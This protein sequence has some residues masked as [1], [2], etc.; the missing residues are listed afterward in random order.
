MTASRTC[1][2]CGADLP[3][4]VRW[5]LRCYEP[6]RELTP[7]APVWGDDEFVD[8]PIVTKGPVPHWSRWEKS[9]TTFGPA[10][11]VVV[12][13]LAA[14]WLLSSAFNTPITVIFVLPLSM[15]IVRNVWRP[16]WVIPPHLQAP[17]D[18]PTQEPLRAWLWDRSDFVSSLLLAIASAVGVGILLSVQ[19]PIPRFVVMVTA[20]VTV[21]CWIY[22]KVAGDR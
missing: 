2:A 22:R 11:R 17:I 12:T 16:G 8:T 5:C 15:L 19:N 21:A 4:D 3:G 10:G 7:R 6:A 20:V 18:T 14:L 13:V 1:R 9:A